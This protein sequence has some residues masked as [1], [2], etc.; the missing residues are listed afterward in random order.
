MSQDIDYQRVYQYRFNQVAVD[1]KLAV[2]S[3]IAPWVWQHMGRPQRIL[4]P[5]A[6]S[7]EFLSCVP[8]PHRWG[9]DMVAPP[10]V[11]DGIT[12][13]HSDFF[14]AQLPASSFDGMF[15]SN[16][17]E[18]LHSPEE[19]AQFL[20]RSLGLLKPGGSLFIMGPNFK[21][22]GKEYF[23]CAD[24][25]LALT[26]ISVAEHLY[27]AGFEL[28]EV[29]GRFLPYSFR[30]LLPASKVLT[31]MYLGLPLAWSLLGKQFLLLARRPLA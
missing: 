10:T 6:G 2:W 28:E 26:H 5:A 27:A 3:A 9:V 18:H 13:V 4:D 20:T 8:A 24:H 7:M 29:R 30:S 19:I 11:P 12:F 31:Q 21:Y 16:F 25:R 23:D 22:C 15:V 1:K 14:A 17:L